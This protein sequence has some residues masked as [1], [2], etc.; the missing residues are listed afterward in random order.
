M[1]R[2]ATICLVV[3]LLWTIHVRG[4]DAAPDEAVFRTARLTLGTPMVR[5][6]VVRLGG[7]GAW[8]GKLPDLRLKLESEADW[9]RSPLEMENRLRGL[10]IRWAKS[11]VWVGYEVPTEGSEPRATFSIQRGF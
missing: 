5:E 9:L 11:P 3:L 10:E 1:L 4:Q 7:D 6:A 8:I 2:H